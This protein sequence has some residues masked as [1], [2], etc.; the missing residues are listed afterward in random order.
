MTGILSGLACAYETLA[1]SISSDRQVTSKRRIV[2]GILTLSIANSKRSGFECESNP[3][4]VERRRLNQPT[5][6]ISLSY[7]DM[8]E[9]SFSPVVGLLRDELQESFSLSLRL[10]GESSYNGPSMESLICLDEKMFM[11]CSYFWCW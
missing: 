2:L 11:S 10:C 1:N 5:R 9:R 4:P 7:A 6:K 3:V 8:D